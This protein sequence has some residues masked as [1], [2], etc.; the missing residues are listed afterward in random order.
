VPNGSLTKA[1]FSQPAFAPNFTNNS[2]SEAPSA[3]VE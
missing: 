2:E 1:R 3:P